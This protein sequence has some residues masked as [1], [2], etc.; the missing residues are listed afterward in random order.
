MA[1]GDD[2]PPLAAKTQPDEGT[3]REQ[4]LA[5]I[6]RSKWA[7]SEEI[8]KQ[9]P[10]SIWKVKTNNGCTPLMMAIV[11]KVPCSTLQVFLDHGAAET[12][13]ATKNHKTAADIAEIHLQKTAARVLRALEKDADWPRCSICGERADPYHKL[14]RLEERVA[15]GQDDN[16]LVQYF[17][18]EA[19]SDVRK[20]LS[21]P[22]FHTFTSTHYHFRKEMTESMAVMETLERRH[23]AGPFHVVDLLCGKSMT[24]SVAALRYNCPVTAVDFASPNHLPHFGEAGLDVTYLQVDVLS[25][26]FLP[27]LTERIADVG[28]P[29]VVL[30]VHACGLLSMVAVDAFHEIPAVDM[31]T[32]LPCCLPTKSDPRSPANVFEAGTTEEE[33]YL[34]WSRYLRD[35]IGSQAEMYIAEGVV[36]PKRAVVFGMK[37]Q[38]DTTPVP[39]G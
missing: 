12:A 9:N 26:D 3:A 16:P 8:A 32:L 25:S 33:K 29:T 38:A 13:A 19:W 21:T 4:L 35:Q 18:S 11:R 14:S 5:A 2:A 20:A 22:H 28:L 15:R 31:V 7:L 39:A 1:D 23:K 36:S 17:F 6:N 24:A 37:S 10:P 34:R 30:G 27:R